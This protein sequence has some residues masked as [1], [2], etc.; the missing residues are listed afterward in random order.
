[1]TAYLAPSALLPDGWAS[2]VLIE[3]GE[4]GAISAVTKGG[5]ADG[6]ER[7]A[8]PVIP[9]MPNLH[10]HAFQRAMA[11]L[12]ETAANPS[13]D[14]WTWRDL[15]Y[16]FLGRLGPEEMEAVAAQLYLEMLKAGYTAVGEFHYVHNAPDGTP[17]DDPAE[18]SRRIIAAARRAGIG[19]THLPVLYA[20]G[21]FDGRELAGGQRRFANE[22]AGILAIVAELRKA[23][24]DD[25]NIRLGVAPHSLRAVA[26]EQL[27]EL[28]AGAWAEDGMAPIHIHVAEQTREVEDCRAWSGARPVEWLLAHAPVDGR[29]CLIHATHMTPAETRGLA[30]SD[31]VAGLCPSTE[32]NLGDGLF[33]LTDY[34]A[35]D[36]VLGVGS[37]SHIGID[38]AEELRLLE[39]GQ[40]LTLRR[41]SVTRLDG[42]S[43][44]AGLYRAA[45]AGGA[46][47]M[48]RDIGRIAKGARAD[49]VVLDPDHPALVEREGDALLDA[50]IFAATG[51]TPVRDVMVGGRWRVKEGHHED[52]EDVLNLYRATVRKLKDG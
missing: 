33:A 29:W 20:Q 9:G 10:S 7:L 25:S 12:A 35:A 24:A 49:F 22:P 19:I 17:Y 18:L 1:M 6:A 37:D 27:A 44:G 41:R 21:G 11:G 3:T 47:A 52:E 16:R 14:F 2:D 4:D 46:Q 26:P 28:V 39:Y 43:I 48:G 45:L 32:A 31:A 40:R 23:H 15:M 34:L 5:E 50:L 38:P 36:G 30:A 42:P 51:P 8:G 13:D